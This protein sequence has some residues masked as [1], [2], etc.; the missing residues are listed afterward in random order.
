M[1][2]RYL[3]L[4]AVFMPTAL[5]LAALSYLF[6]APDSQTEAA[7]TS[8]I[9]RQSP[10]V[11]DTIGDETVIA[12]IDTDAL[13][14]SGPRDEDAP[15]APAAQPESR[16][17]PA[18]LESSDIIG[19][20]LL[21][22]STATDASAD[23]PEPTLRR[24][25]LRLA[26]L[27]AAGGGGGVPGTTGSSKTSGDSATTPVD[28][29]NGGSDSSTPGGS[30]SIGGDTDPNGG[31]G[32]GTGGESGAAPNIPNPDHGSNGAESGDGNG[33]HEGNDEEDPPI[34]DSDPDDDAPAYDP[35]PDEREPP[36]VQVP[37]PAG[38]GLML[39]GLLG[40]AAGRRRKN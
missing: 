32:E 2:R 13:A 12:P 8:P 6:L 31:K 7:P 37:E 39:L 5:G 16:Q 30:S 3:W 26:S 34:S 29:S 38:I 17:R 24:G 27:S 15:E 10:L 23:T 20:P 14:P 22:S 18:H 40:C 9:V 21:A 11:E 4:L 28:V 35:I 33:G 36:V 1:R 19:P 25:S